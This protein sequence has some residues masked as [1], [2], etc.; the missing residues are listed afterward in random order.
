MAEPAWVGLRCL[1]KY[2]RE[3]E[4]VIVLGKCGGFEDPGG[5]EQRSQSR[6]SMS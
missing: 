3:P 5:G 1:V 6:M 2:W 4:E